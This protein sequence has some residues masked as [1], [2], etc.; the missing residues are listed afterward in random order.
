VSTPVPT[1][2]GFGVGAVGAIIALFG[3]LG[4]RHRATI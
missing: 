1:M 4:L 2:T 3:M